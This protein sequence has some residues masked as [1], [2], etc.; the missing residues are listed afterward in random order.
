MN[1]MLW[2]FAVSSI[3]GI[4]LSILCLVFLDRNITRNKKNILIIVFFSSLLSLIGLILPIIDAV[5]S[6]IFLPVIFRMI[7]SIKYKESYAIYFLSFN[8]IVLFQLI[9]LIISSFVFSLHTDTHPILLLL[10]DL[11]CL[12]IFIYMYFKRTFLQKIYWLIIEKNAIIL[13][14]FLSLNF[15]VVFV[16]LLYRF[17]R[18]F[19]ENAFSLLEGILAISIIVFIV[20]NSHL[21]VEASKAKVLQHKKI[22]EEVQ[23]LMAEVIRKQHENKNHMNAILKAVD[24]IDDIVL[25]RNKLTEYNTDLQNKTYIKEQ[26]VFKKLDRVIVES[27]IISKIL[28]SNSLGINFEYNIENVTFSS[29]IE[30]YILC[31][32]IGCLLDNAFESGSNTVILHIYPLDESGFSVIEVKNKHE[33]LSN[34][35]INKMFKKGVSTKLKEKDHI[36]G[37]GLYNLNKITEKN[38]IKIDV[39]NE[40][41]EDENYVV[42]SLILES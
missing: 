11:I 12:A 8:I 39:Y 7:F 37:Y 32:I 3:Q 21:K 22:N 4:S 15:G 20:L 17:R 38:D 29:K 34:T 31:E 18:S 35:F 16:S 5:L 1:N 27:L 10:F 33:K 9:L 41:L 19:W 26:N 2:H 14:S 23:E 13:T 36:R 25:L 28:K 24:A 30:D 6:M 40:L 42:F